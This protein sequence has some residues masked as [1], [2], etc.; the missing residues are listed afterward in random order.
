MAETLQA[1]GAVAPTEEIRSHFPA[2]EREHEG[3]RVAYFD[4]PGGT[5]VPR[6]VVESVSDYLYHHNANTHWAYPTSA[7]TDEIIERS[8]A[9]LADFLNASPSEIVF[10]ANATT[11]AFH[12]SRTLGRTFEAGDEIVVTELDHHA[13]VAP[14][15]ALERE[16]GIVLRV[17]RMDTETGA[18]DWDDFESKV[19]ASTKVVAIGAASNALG[20]LN[21]LARAGRLTEEVCAYMF[22]DAVHYAPHQL[23][24]VRAMRCD[25]LVCSAYKFYGPHVGAMFCRR[26]LLD[27][28]PF[29]KLIPAPD[30]APEV[31]ET[32]TQNHEGIAG[33]AAAVEFLASLAPGGTRRERL[34]YAF[35]ALHARGAALTRKM[36]DGLSRVEGVT[37]YGPRADEPRTPTV[38]FTVR[39][40]TSTDVARSLAARGV[41]VSHG[42]FYAATVVERLE[43]GPEGLV[44][45]GCACY[46]NEE[47]VERLIEGVR[48][49]TR[50]GGQAENPFS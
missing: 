22:V 23:V 21:D 48:E 26:E 32:G 2:L 37:L 28:L 5:Q 1:T 31:A 10:G 44:R 27:S 38:A 50:N 25:F 34:R 18:L 17:V 7:E 15:H 43:L 42:D 45:A 24:D 4:G 36:W 33:A 8:R 14:W 40:V 16:R 3:T 49:V 47:E 12:V 11:L 41:F 13:N 46:T 20:T 6:A 29:P 9:G 35:D 39:G 30:Y 19:N